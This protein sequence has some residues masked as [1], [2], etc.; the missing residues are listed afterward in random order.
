MTTEEAL[1]VVESVL[2]EYSGIKRL[3]EILEPIMQAEVRIAELGIQA[4]VLQKGVDELKASKVDLELEIAEAKKV[5]K[6]AHVATIAR[7][8][9]L[10]TAKWDEVKVA[11]ARLEGL[12]VRTAEMENS[13][14]ATA[15]EISDYI[16]GLE[17]KAEAAEYRLEKVEAKIAELKGI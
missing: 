15:G 12:R 5:A 6:G 8:R 13:F 2:N 9:N 16:A 3:A 7:M 11:E 4:G 14:S 17:V 1:R 10:E